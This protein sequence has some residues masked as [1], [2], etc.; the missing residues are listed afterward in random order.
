ML[1]LRGYMVSIISG[2]DSLSGSWWWFP[3]LLVTWRWE[4]RRGTITKGL[5]LNRSQQVT[6]GYPGLAYQAL[7]KSQEGWPLSPSIVV[8][9]IF[10]WR[11][12]WSCS[13][14]WKGRCVIAWLGSTSLYVPSTWVSEVQRELWSHS[15]GGSSWHEKGKV[16]VAPA[17]LRLACQI[18][19][20]SS[21]CLVDGNPSLT[22]PQKTLGARKSVRSQVWL[23]V[24]SKP[25]D[26][27]ALPS[28]NVHVK[29]PFSPKPRF[30]PWCG[31]GW[32]REGEEA[33]L[34][35]PVYPLFPLHP[36]SPLSTLSL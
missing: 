34:R 28:S 11:D 1:P 6:I 8:I 35:G 16:S 24:Y 33:I 17:I 26:P 27:G 15:G 12:R 4:A 10:L 22:L 3:P 21:S 2:S 20:V 31:P 5:R 13:Q 9:C 25:P 30:V 18:S 29:L 7:N 14:E 19:A 36:T 32:A 23:H